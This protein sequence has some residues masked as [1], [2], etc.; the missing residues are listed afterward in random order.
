MS[1]EKFAKERGFSINVDHSFVS[2]V[3]DFATDA[4]NAVVHMVFPLAS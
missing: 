2:V 3:R 1:T 4:F